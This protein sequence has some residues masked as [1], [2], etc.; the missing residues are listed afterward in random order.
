MLRSIPDP[1]PDDL[2]TP[3]GI[4]EAVL[5]TGSR[6]PNAEELEIFHGQSKEDFFEAGYRRAL[7]EF[8][9][10]LPWAGQAWTDS[11]ITALGDKLDTPYPG[12][13]I[14]EVRAVSYDGDE[15]VTVDV[16]GVTAEVK[17][18]YLY[19]F[20]ARQ[21][22]GKL[23]PAEALQALPRTPTEEPSPSLPP[24]PVL[25]PP[26]VPPPVPD[27]LPPEL[28]DPLSPPP[29]E[30]T[31]SASTPPETN[32][33]APAP[34]SAHEP[35][36]PLRRW[37]YVSSRGVEGMV[38]AVTPQQAW[39]RARRHYTVRLLVSDKGAAFVAS[40]RVDLCIRQAMADWSINRIET[41][42]RKH[43]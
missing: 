40:T 23:L 8:A 15:Y 42:L 20:P 17:A 24:E 39:Q 11:P 36:G 19:L 18:D 5:R 9:L 21:D 43:G 29:E 38:H 1:L 26:P 7:R 13:P 28:P 25:P 41:A 32:T 34:V 2:T 27:P 14:R 37:I 35:E 31:A 4:R 6:P 33:A 10:R 30:V 16:E 3:A 22:W 12:A